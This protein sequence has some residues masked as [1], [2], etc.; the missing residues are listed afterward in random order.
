MLGIIFPTDEL[1]DFQ[2]GRAQPSTRYL[3]LSF[4]GPR[5]S[6]RFNWDCLWWKCLVSWRFG[7]IPPIED[8]ALSYP[9]W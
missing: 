3:Q 1:R 7:E 4:G 8:G 6:P 9:K 2:R 5:A